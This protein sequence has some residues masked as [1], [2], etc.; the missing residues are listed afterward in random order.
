MDGQWGPARERS[1]PR[2]P[3][4][5]S[6][7]KS[8]NYKVEKW[9][10]GGQKIRNEGQAENPI[11]HIFSR[12]LRFQKGG[13]STFLRRVWLPH[14]AVS[15]ASE[16]GAETVAKFATFPRPSLPN[17]ATT[18]GAAE[19]QRERGEIPYDSAKGDNEHMTSTLRGWRVQE[20]PYFADKQH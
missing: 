10:C 19:P 6:L 9:D 5:F 2:H 16:R 20:L 13:R 14:S 17:A 4:F 8:T 18:T 3:S 12:K 7:R 15:L 1:V 11:S